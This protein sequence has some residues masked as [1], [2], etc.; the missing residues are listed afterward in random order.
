VK[1]IF[2]LDI[3]GTAVKFALVGLDGRFLRRGEIPFDRTLHFPKFVDQ[4]VA[5]YHSVEKVSP[6]CAVGICMPGYAVRDTGQIIDGAGNVPV[7]REGSLALVLSERLGLPVLVENDG[8]AAAQGELAYG[9]GRTLRRFVLFTVG[10]GVG[11]AVVIDGVAITGTR[12]EPPELGAIVVGRDARTGKQQSLEAAA[13]ASGILRAYAATGGEA[14]SIRELFQH[15]EA[16]NDR[17]LSAICEACR[18]IA[19]AAGMLV[20]SLGLEAIVI[21]GGVSGAGETL[22]QPIR[23]LLPEYTWPFLSK[24]VRIMTAELGN[25]AG[26]LGVAA[27][28][29]RAFQGHELA[30]LQ[31]D[32]VTQITRSK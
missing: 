18:A 4:L 25:D 2:A 17:A 9:A 30:V 12:G 1:T 24:R 15:A 19:H 6:P 23:S 32:G 14:R 27:T 11:G 3:G 21:G 28:A 20:N 7:L 16:G 31:S 22:I 10:T 29:A 8:V 13:S 5:A 26:L